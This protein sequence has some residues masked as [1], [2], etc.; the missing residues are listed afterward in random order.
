MERTNLLGSLYGTKVRVL[1]KSH[2]VLQCMGYTKI[3][4][5]N[6]SE[7]TFVDYGDIQSIWQITYNKSSLSN[8][9]KTLKDFSIKP[10]YF[11]RV[12]EETNPT[13]DISVFY[14]R[15]DYPDPQ[16]IDDILLN[17][18]AFDPGSREVI[19]SLGKGDLL[20]MIDPGEAK[21]TYRW[22]YLGE[23]KRFEHNVR[24]SW[25]P[26]GGTDFITSALKQLK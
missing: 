18:Y 17:K 22:T 5:N 11:T 10:L 12:T 2:G 14:E 13:S 19:S 20:L 26:H 3:T 9:S 25:C 16:L 21:G 1:G 4:A 7:F 8:S 6:K 23:G 24:L 15:Q